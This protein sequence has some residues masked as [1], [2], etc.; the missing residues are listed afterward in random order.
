MCDTEYLFWRNSI[1][2]SCKVDVLQSWLSSRK[3][4]C[5]VLSVPDIGKSQ[6]QYTSIIVGSLSYLQQKKTFEIIFSLNT[7]RSSNPI[8][9]MSAVYYTVEIIRIIEPTNFK[10]LKSKLYLA[11]TQL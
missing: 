3:T 6:Y 10:K 7:G 9:N 1:S 11:T 4:N 8:E 5:T 2:I